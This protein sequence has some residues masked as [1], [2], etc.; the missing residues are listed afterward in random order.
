MLLLGVFQ[1][2]VLHLIIWFSIADLKSSGRLSQY[3]KTK[4]KKTKTNKKGRAWTICMVD[5]KQ[6]YSRSI[7]FKES[8]NMWWKCWLQTITCSHCLLDY[9]VPLHDSTSGECDN[10]GPYNSQKVCADLMTEL[11]NIWSLQE[12]GRVIDASTMNMLMAENRITEGERRKWEKPEWRGKRKGS[13]SAATHDPRSFWRKPFKSHSRMHRTLLLGEFWGMRW[14]GLAVLENLSRRW[15]R[16]GE[17]QA[18][19][20]L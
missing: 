16:I 3:A 19:I 8:V 11:C 14:E 12:K 20:W 18:E 9:S 17:Q 13:G 6:R 7:D 1:F 15:E 4:T 5:Q 2:S 10:K